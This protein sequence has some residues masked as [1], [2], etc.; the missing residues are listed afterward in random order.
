MTPSA[1]CALTPDKGPAARRAF[2]PLAGRRWREA[3]DEGRHSSHFLPSG[4]APPPPPRPP[5]PRPP[6]FFLRGAPPPPPLRGTLSPQAGRGNFSVGTPL[7]LFRF[8]GNFRAGAPSPS[9]AS[10]GTS[11]QEGDKSS[12]SVTLW[13]R[14]IACPRTVT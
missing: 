4:G 12:R 7:V 9:F 10:L 11:E 1:R 14:L 5:P 13:M 8:A 6:P 2:A 3:P